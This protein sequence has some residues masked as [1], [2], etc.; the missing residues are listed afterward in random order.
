MSG[1]TTQ[2]HQ[3]DGAEIIKRTFTPEF[4][5]RLDAIIQFSPLDSK[6]ILHVVDKFIS[7]LE[8]QLESKKVEIQVEAS[9]KIG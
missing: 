3:S 9:A 6:T 8:A 5:N 4:R 1:F 7:Q 2:D